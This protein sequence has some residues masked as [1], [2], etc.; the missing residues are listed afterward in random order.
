GAPDSGE[1]EA[2]GGTATTA[3]LPARRR[4]GLRLAGLDERVEMA[5]HARGA[6]PQTLADLRRGDGTF[7]EQQLHDGGAGLPLRD[8]AT[9]RSRILAGVLDAR[10]RRGRCV[11]CAFCGVG[12]VGRVFHNTSVTEFGSTVHQGCPLL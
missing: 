1:L 12:G 5:S 6:E 8:L 9:C 3:S 10:R 4:G 2:A 11:T 7:F